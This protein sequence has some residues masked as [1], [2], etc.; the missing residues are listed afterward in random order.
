MDTWA[1]YKSVFMPEIRAGKLIPLM[2]IGATR[3]LEL[4]DVPLLTDLVKGDPDK[5]AV[6]EFLTTALAVSRPVAT[7]PGV[8]AERLEIL[9]RAFDATMQ[10]P[11]FVSEA[12][13]QS[14]EIDP[15]S[16]E[17]VEAAIRRILGAPK[18][19]IGRAKAALEGR[20]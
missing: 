17:E 16:G 2:Q 13:K 18:E 11:D 20:R 12:R 10:D 15:M 1:G 14:L 7:T 5:L 4:P 19:L 3:E 8:P 6:A 9:R